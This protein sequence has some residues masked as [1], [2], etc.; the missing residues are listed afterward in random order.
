MRETRTVQI[1]IFEF[2]SA[3]ETGVQL[4]RISQRLDE[5]PGILVLV[6]KDLIAKGCKSRGRKGLSV[7][8]VLRCLIL[9]QT[10][11]LSY[12]RLAFHLS[13]SLSFR[14]F[15]RLNPGDTPGKSALQGGIRRLSPTTLGQV[16]AALARDDL[17]A[18][19]LEP[20]QIRLD[21]TVVESHILD[22]RDSQLLDDG[23]RV[24]S[25]LLAKSAEAT[26]QK[27][28]FKDHRKASK[29]LARRLFYT[30]VGDQAP[31]YRELLALAKKT[32]GQAERGLAQVGGTPEAQHWADRVKH[33]RDL[34]GRVIDQTRRRVL[35]GEKV[36]AQ[37][38]LVS[39]FEP[40]TDIIVKS[41]R[42][43][44][45][46]H[47]I[48]LV[49][50]RQ[51]MVTALLLEDGNPADSVRFLPALQEHADLCGAMP[52]AVAADGGYASVAN[53]SAGR[54][55]GVSRVVF[56]KKRGL[57][58]RQMG[59]QQKTYEKL[60]DFRAGIEGNISELKRAFGV[61]R[62]KWR[63]RDG[64]DA[65]VWA[66]VISYNLMRIARLDSG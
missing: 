25:R 7:E 33:Y 36:P 66:S 30:P 58:L 21:S 3:H 39:L 28:R 8:S 27:V 19:R 52:N 49:T 31:L 60:R 47:K 32:C 2:Y 37:D 12:E 20:T 63:G 26:G 65:Y 14:S 10:F 51:G 13:D 42:D 16:F 56:H 46:G 59:V 23:I 11:S 54:E 44:Q 50:D 40:H 57:S 48:N 38:K 22:P 45:Y 9:K 24:L 15:A 5:T 6:E 29:S 55:L 53:V 17:A 62:A 64:F 1:S 4:E 18:G 34:L 43:V 41:R 35:D 61:G